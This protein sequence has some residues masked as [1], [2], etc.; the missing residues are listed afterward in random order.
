M[1]AGYAVLSADRRKGHDNLDLS[2]TTS[3]MHMPL[4]PA[5]H[6]VALAIGVFAESEEEG[7]ALVAD[8]DRLRTRAAEAAFDLSKAKAEL[9]AFATRYPLQ[10]ERTVPA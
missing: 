4:F 8:M 1:W 10:R 3:L 9:V 6:F 7:M 5:D 2:L